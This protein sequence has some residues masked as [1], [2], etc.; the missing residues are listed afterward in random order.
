MHG[1]MSS[2]TILSKGPEG[3]TPAHEDKPAA[4]G[5]LSTK[6]ESA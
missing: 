1:N 6:Q 5:E 4:N 2:S 3:Q